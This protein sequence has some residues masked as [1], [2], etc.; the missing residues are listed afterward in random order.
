MMA[1]APGSRTLALRCQIVELRPE[2]HGLAGVLLS[3]ATLFQPILVSI[4][5]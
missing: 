2:Y 4:D 3:A 5:S 1:E